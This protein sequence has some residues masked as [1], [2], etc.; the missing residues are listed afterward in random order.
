ME[1]Q[2]L[3]RLSLLIDRT[4]LRQGIREMAQRIDQDFPDVGSMESEPLMV[5]VLKGGFIFA[6]DLLTFMNRPVPVIFAA[7]RMVDGAVMMSRE[8]ESLIAGR[9]LIVVDILLDS[10]ISQKRLCDSLRTHNPA[11]IRLAVL[12]HKTVA[13]TEDLAIDYLGFEVPDVRLVGYGLDENQRFRGMDGIYT[14]WTP[15]KRI[16]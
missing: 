10:G 1:K 2:T 7:P 16:F 9:N 14:W 13:E 11:S 4:H 5:V 8:D 12:L 15:G 3:E 6:A